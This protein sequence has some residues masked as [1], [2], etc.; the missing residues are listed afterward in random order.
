MNPARQ[1][2]VHPDAEILNGFVESALPEA[3]R[4]EVL[5]HLG[6]C[7]RCR[8]IVYLAQDAMPAAEAPATAPVIERRIVDGGRPWILRSRPAWAAAFAFATIAA[9]AVFVTIRDNAPPREMAKLAE[10]PSAPIPAAPPPAVP[11]APAQSEQSTS[12]LQAIAPGTSAPKANTRTQAEAAVSS[13]TP[14]AASPAPPPAAALQ[15]EGGPVPQSNAD[16]KSFAPATPIESSGQVT[17]AKAAP[18]AEMR[19][20]RFHGAPGPFRAGTPGGKAPANETGAGAAP[21]SAGTVDVNVDSAQSQKEAVQPSL[22]AISPSVAAGAAADRK[23]GLVLLPSGLPLV[24]TAE[25]GQMQ[26]ALDAVGSLF[27]SRDLGKTWQPVER[28]WAG[29]AVKVQLAR[30]QKAGNAPLS[31]TIEKRESASPAEATTPAA[32]FE[33]VNDRNAIWT[34]ADGK[35]WMAK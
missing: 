12:E 20:T 21:R 10:N 31:Q 24:S 13:T 26:L 35:T 25:A 27:L 32:L 1:F 17:A 19:A 29:R 11:K 2:D 9:V 7:G 18:S 34:S 22:A 5:A 33:I 6:G 30:W 28:Q 16:A 14:V 4:L 15:P 8:Q 23:S 3:E